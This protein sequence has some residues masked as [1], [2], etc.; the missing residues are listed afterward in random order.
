MA[1]QHNLSNGVYI[2]FIMANFISTSIMVWPMPLLRSQNVMYSSS[3]TMGLNAHQML[4]PLARQT[5][6]KRD[7]ELT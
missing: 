7:P 2:F 4:V 3:A 5:D 1:S 6:V